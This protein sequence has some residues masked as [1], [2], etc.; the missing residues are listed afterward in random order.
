[1]IGR[2]SFLVALLAFTAVLAPGAFA[3]T[4]HDWTPS[5]DWITIDKDYS[6]RRYVDLDQINPANVGKLKE[7][8]EIR[9]NELTP[10]STGI[11]KVGRTLYVN[12]ARSTVAFDAA[13]CA[14]RWQYTVEF[15]APTI[16]NNNRGSA[17]LNGKIFRGA[18]DGQLIALDARTG[19]KRW[20]VSARDTNQLETL[21][22][23]PIA[24]RGKVFIGIAIGDL[25]IAGRLMAFDADS[26]R[27]LW[28]FNTTLDPMV[29]QGGGFWNSYSLDP[30]TGEIFAPVANPRPDFNRDIEPNDSYYTQYTESII[31][32]NAA[33]GQLDWYKTLV[34]RD[35]RDWDV[36]VP[37]TLYETEDGREMLAAT[38]K[39]GRVYG[40][41]RTSH[42]EMFNTPATTMMNDQAPTPLHWLYVRQPCL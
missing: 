25:P 26:G 34:P 2:W 30:K 18:P 29:L 17:Y 33:T 1:M 27:R 24:W 15:V 10:F 9:L 39:S 41:D 37:P 32:V 40:I 5:D 7:V 38:G 19:E 8:C 22:S 6:S 36:G 35:D 3:Q 23:A 12:T 11:L 13:T 28:S 42:Y 20:S 14:K 21:V 16:G 4:S 31:A